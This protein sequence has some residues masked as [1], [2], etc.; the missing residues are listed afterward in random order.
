MGFDNILNNEYLQSKKIIILNLKITLLNNTSNIAYKH[1][2][3]ETTNY[4]KTIHFT[5]YEKRRF[6]EFKI[7]ICNSI[8]LY[9]YFYKFYV[10]KK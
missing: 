1:F 3:S 10:T 5:R 7:L 9:L 8:M 6:I 2:P 4:V